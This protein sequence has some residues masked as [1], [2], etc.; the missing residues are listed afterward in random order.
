MGRATF[1]SLWDI[2]TNGSAQNPVTSLWLYMLHSKMYGKMKVMRCGVCKQ[3]HDNK[4]ITGSWDLSVHVHGNL[5]TSFSLFLPF[6]FCLLNIE[7]RLTDV[8]QISAWKSY[9]FGLYIAI[10]YTFGTLKLLFAC[11][12]LNKLK[13]LKRDSFKLS[14]Y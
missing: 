4:E 2:C 14:L 10:F 8:F 11:H 7:R 5:R 3:Y 12:H 9:F 6:F 1:T 13:Q